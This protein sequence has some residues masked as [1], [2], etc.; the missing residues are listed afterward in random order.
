MLGWGLWHNMWG[1]K[2]HLFVGGALGTVCEE[3]PLPHL[4]QCR[5]L[6]F[7]GPMCDST[8][9]QLTLL[10]QLLHFLLLLLCLF[11]FVTPA[12][13]WWCQQHSSAAQ[14][15]PK[16]P[17][18]AFLLL[19]K[20]SQ[21][22]LTGTWC[23]FPPVGRSDSEPKHV[24]PWNDWANMLQGMLHPSC[25]LMPCFCFFHSDTSKRC[26]LFFFRVL[27]LWLSNGFSWHIALLIVFSYGLHD[28]LVLLCSTL[29]S[30][31]ATQLH[32]SSFFFPAYK[33]GP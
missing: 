24:I 16:A 11:S 26:F 25:S 1:A 15:D 18:N 14:H 22:T 23:F 19:D 10:T 4:A 9:T 32:D 2:P 5:M 13:L 30:L 20:A 29:S 21:A 17:L 8:Y 6:W 27:S 12:L 28:I 3:N 33:S 31:A 7:L